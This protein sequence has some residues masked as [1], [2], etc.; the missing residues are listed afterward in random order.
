[1]DVLVQLLIVQLQLPCT[2]RNQL[3]QMLLMPEQLP[4]RFFA[5][6]N[7]LHCSLDR[8]PVQIV[9]PRHFVDHRHL[10]VLVFMH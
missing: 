10:A 4:F 3:L 5:L 7:V 6:R 8:R 9:D 1:M 2:F